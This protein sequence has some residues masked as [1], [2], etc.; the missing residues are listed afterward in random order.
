MGI[1][2]VF[3]ILLALIYGGG[4]V[5]FKA[6]GI[7]WDLLPYIIVVLFVLAIIDWFRSRQ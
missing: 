2:L 1:V 3:A 5:F 4:V 7:V 6:A